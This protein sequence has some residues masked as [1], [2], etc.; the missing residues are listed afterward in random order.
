MKAQVTLTTVVHDRPPAFGG[1]PTA[2]S[3]EAMQ[4]IN[5]AL[6]Q[7]EQRGVSADFQIVAGDAA[8][9]ITRLAR[10]VE[11]D[12]IVVGSRGLGAMR[13]TLLG[14]VSHG[15]LNHTPCPVL[16]VPMTGR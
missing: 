13:S 7:A 16:V 15:I 12:L 14:S 1:E 2:P 3:D 8:D 6:G 5:D 9:E 11:A 4:V 10:S